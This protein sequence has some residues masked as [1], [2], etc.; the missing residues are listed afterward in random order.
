MFARERNQRH[1]NKR[2]Q[3]GLCIYCSNKA[4]PNRASCQLHLDRNSYN[5]KKRRLNA[6]IPT[7]NTWS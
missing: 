4:V 6:K 2:K 1:R 7:E 5:K 3:L